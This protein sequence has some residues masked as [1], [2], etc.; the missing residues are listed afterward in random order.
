MSGRKRAPRAGLLRDHVVEGGCSFAFALFGQVLFTP[1]QP[2]RHRPATSLL[3]SSR[4][5]ALSY[6]SCF[7]RQS[8]ILCDYDGPPT[9]SADVRE[10]AS[11]GPTEAL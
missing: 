5:L 6:L 7:L 3:P 2:N 1:S 4:A 9:G 8:C 11:C 10:Y